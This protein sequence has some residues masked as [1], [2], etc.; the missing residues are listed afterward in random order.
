MA[1]LFCRSVGMKYEHYIPVSFLGMR[2]VEIK[3]VI[4]K[5]SQIQTGGRKRCVSRNNLAFPNDH[6]VVANRSYPFSI[7]VSL[8]KFS[9][10]CYD[11]FI[12]IVNNYTENDTTYLLI[13]KN[14]ILV[15][16]SKYLL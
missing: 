1:M 6:K 3:H 2:Q 12:E 14:N 4:S 7:Q 8:I 16:Y 15:K 10:A 5:M 11:N 9:N 13:I